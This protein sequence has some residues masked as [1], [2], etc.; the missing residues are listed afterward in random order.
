MSAYWI[1]SKNVICMKYINLKIITW[2]ICAL[3]WTTKL[4]QRSV[5]QS[6]CTHRLSDVAVIHT[7]AQRT[8][9]SQPLGTLPLLMTKL[10]YTCQESSS[11]GKNTINTEEAQW[12]FI[13]QKFTF[14]QEV[15]V[16]WN[17]ETFN[18]LFL[19][20]SPKGR[21]CRWVSFLYY[22]FICSPSPRLGTFCYFLS[23]CHRVTYQ[24]HPHWH[25]Q[26]Y[27]CL[28]SSLSA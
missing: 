2:G 5:K 4:R 13:F 26:T 28:K 23:F 17:L 1:C 22:L 16:S 7:E 19:P 8:V 3:L 14:L 21:S 6:A 24:T 27:A 12:V 15:K 10:F 18:C 25:L 20:N 11:V 9:Y